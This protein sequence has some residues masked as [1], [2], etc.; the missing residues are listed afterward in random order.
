MKFKKNWLNVLDD[1][2][3]SPLR[4]LGP[5]SSGKGLGGEIA[6]FLSLHVFT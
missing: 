1:S 3:K 2:E 4:A 5:G 6:G